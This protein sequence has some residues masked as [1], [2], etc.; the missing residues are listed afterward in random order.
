MKAL[1]AQD[2]VAPTPR[3]LPAGDG[4][5]SS[6]PGTREPQ[7]QLDTR[8]LDGL[9]G[10]AALYVFI[11][12]ASVIL[13]I[14]PDHPALIDRLVSSGIFAF[15]FA[16]AAVLFFF[17][18]SGF[19]IHLRYAQ[20]LAANPLGATFDWGAFV[21]RRFR[22][23]YPPLL[24]ALA[25]T[26]VFDSIGLRLHFPI[27]HLESVPHRI[28][29]SHLDLATLAA[30]L[31]FLVNV[32]VPTPRWGVFFTSTFWGS[33]VPLW[34][35]TL[36]WWFYM[37]YPA[38]WWL[39]KRSIA[40]ATCAVGVGFGLHYIVQYL[41]PRHPWIQI[42]HLPVMTLTAL[43]GWWIGALL[44]DV[45]AR[46][47][48]VSFR[49]VFAPLLILFLLPIP[50]RW[51]DKLFTAVYARQIKGTFWAFTPL[52]ILLP[53]TAGISEDITGDHSLQIIGVALGFAGLLALFFALQEY[54]HKFRLLNSLKWLGDMSYTL[55]L[56]HMPI[57]VF[58]SGWV[59]SRTPQ[60]TL[61]HTPW[62]L[63]GTVVGVVAVAWL[64]HFVVERP[65]MRTRSRSAQPTLE[66]THAAADSSESRQTRVS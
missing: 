54:G 47:L 57:C 38:F 15:R 4:G 58:I 50:S 25:V 33:D 64:S 27:Y 2:V 12:H 30:N 7:K 24:F 32:H 48:K 63:G 51:I 36:E 3:L 29:P 53:I 62:I 40:L 14:R 31:T 23:L 44:A 8:F 56:I 9:R 28:I 52:V 60:R 22:R 39:S 35:L 13:Y 65:F 61:P 59:M 21:W 34:S 1:Q 37:V 17:V 10:L 18:L 26:Y 5:A 49:A 55:Y 41:E 46:R 16:V 45:Y 19:V 43:P 11:R 6:P 66:G 20:K 42:S